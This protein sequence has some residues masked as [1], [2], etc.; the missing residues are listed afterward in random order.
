MLLERVQ[1]GI[2]IS[3]I[4]DDE[5]ATRIIASVMKKLWHKAPLNHNFPTIA[6]RSKGFQ[7][8]R[9][10]FKGTAQVLPEKIL[11][12]GEELFRYLS[13]TSTEEYVLH[14]DLHHENVLS[15]VR[16]PYLA[17][18]PHGVVGEREHETAAMLRNPQKKLHKSSSIKKVLER[19]IHILSEELGMDKE[20]IR[21]WGVAMTVLSAIWK[22]EDRGTDVKATV[23]IAEV[24]DSIKL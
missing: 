20:R 13:E 24:I 2:P 3:S 5:K 21:Q 22:V 11:C 4:E 9:D 18:D 14:S 10:N 1:P 19:R 17:I 12:K 23:E 6:N 7:R 8:Y 16:E 15:A